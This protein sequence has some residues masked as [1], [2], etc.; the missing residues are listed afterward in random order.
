MSKIPVILVPP[1]SMRDI[2]DSMTPEVKKMCKDY[3]DILADV[4]KSICHERAV[5][6]Q[7]DPDFADWTLEEL[8]R[9]VFEDMKKQ[10]REA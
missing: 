9:L 3:P 5:E 10:V 1:N 2:I 8:E 7:A 4:L 6:L